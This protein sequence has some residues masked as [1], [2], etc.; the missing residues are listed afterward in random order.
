M[1][2]WF[3]SWHGAPT[4]PKWL[5]VGKRA[6]VAPGVASAIAW[7]LMDCASQAEQRGS[8]EK[9]SSEIYS[10]FSGFRVAIIDRVLAAMRDIGM[11]VG[12]RLTAWERR[13]PKREDGSAERAREWRERSRTHANAREPHREEKSRED[14]E[15]NRAEKKEAPVALTAR[16][17]L[18][19]VLDEK[20]ADAVIDHRKAKKAKLTPH[21]AKLL[22]DKFAKCPDPNAA[23][24][25]MI[26]SGWQGFEPE[27]LENRTRGSP[28]GGQKSLDYYENL[29]RK[30]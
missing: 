1:T 2:D 16:E 14:T 3:R 7:A 15:Q 17:E 24:D 13:Q 26:A 18:L 27:W 19:R 21:A 29:G 5:A 10:S 30:Q 4:D 23:A 25:A 8:I 11:I 12:H 28:D 6:K 9:F 20:R 22:A